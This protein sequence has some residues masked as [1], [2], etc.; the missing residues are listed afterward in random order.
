MVHAKDTVSEEDLLDGLGVAGVA[1]CGGVQDY[2][3]PD[4][5]IDKVHTICALKG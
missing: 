1:A 2:E 3:P 5:D 4:D